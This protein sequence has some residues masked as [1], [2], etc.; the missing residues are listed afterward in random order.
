M[1]VQQ[2]LNGYNQ[3]LANFPPSIQPLISI[4]VAVLLIY[5][6]I[7]I[8]QRDFVFIVLLVVLLPASIPVLKNIGD[9][10]VNIVK[11]LFTK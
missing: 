5:A 9:S 8:L 2:L 7:R 3:F 10:I 6:V 11:Y 4:I 1:Y